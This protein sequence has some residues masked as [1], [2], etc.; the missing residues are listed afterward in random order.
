[1]TAASSQKLSKLDD[2]I[3]ATHLYALRLA[4]LARESLI[5]EAELTPKPGLV[6][7]RSSGCHQD[8]SLELMRTYALALEPFFY[9][10]AVASTGS[11]INQELRETLGDLGRRAERSMLKATGGHNTHRGAIWTLGLLISAAAL[12]DSASASAQALTATAQKLACLPDH[13]LAATSH[14]DIAA[15]RYGITGARGEARSGFPHIL[16]CGLP[17][18]RAQ[19]NAGLPE[20]TARLDALLS[21]MATLHDTCVLYRG[22]LTALETLQQHSRAVLIAGGSSTLEGH[23]QFLL[24][25]EVTA[26]LGVSPGGA[27]DL[28]AG[29]LLLDAM[30]RDNDHLQPNEAGGIHGAA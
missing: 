21:I 11:E 2:A 13:T 14:G 10:M 24:L 29:T 20:T 27:A 30:E 5:A 3:H 12:Q 26:K 17:T 6:D 16:R 9:E 4:A 23:A 25:D 15:A 8:L 1:M 22:G 28:L 19:R 18:L 7:Q